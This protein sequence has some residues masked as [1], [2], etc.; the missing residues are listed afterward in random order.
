[1]DLHDLIDLQ[2]AILSEYNN[3]VWKTYGLYVLAIG[4]IMT[5]DKSRSFLLTHPAVRWAVCIA[6]GLVL[7]IEI[8]V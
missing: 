5:S 2:K 4:W 8:P 1:M 6:A 3:N 7:V